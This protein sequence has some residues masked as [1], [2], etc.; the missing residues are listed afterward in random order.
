M[1]FEA[2]L[3]K[4]QSIFGSLEAVEARLEQEKE[5]FIVTQEEIL[6]ISALSRLETL[7]E[8]YCWLY[9]PSS[10]VN[11]NGLLQVLAFKEGADALQI[12]PDNRIAFRQQLE[13]YL[14][15]QSRLLFIAKLYWK[16]L[17][18]IEDII[19]KITKLKL[20]HAKLQQL[21][22]EVKKKSALIFQKFWARWNAMKSS[23]E[24]SLN[25]CSQPG[26]K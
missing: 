8:N 14:N 24:R 22:N 17:K 2:K 26:I 11:V 3:N 1:K 6:K 20:K 5:I 21:H 4:F 9:F 13:R 25:L 10:A 7:L 19:S 12:P 16:E 15:S 23:G 18:S